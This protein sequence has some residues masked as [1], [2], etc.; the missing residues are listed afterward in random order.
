MFASVTVLMTMVV[1]KL[2]EMF[3]DRSKLPPLTQFLISTS[4]IFVE[5]WWLMIVSIIVSIVGIS[6]WK[7]TEE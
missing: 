1:P 4:D 7:E 3:G 2:V 5:Y 6:I